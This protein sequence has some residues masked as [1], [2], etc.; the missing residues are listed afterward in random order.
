MNARNQEN[1]H[2]I[3]AQIKADIQALPTRYT[4][5]IRALR[6]QYSQA[7]KAADSAFMFALAHALIAEI[8]GYGQKWFA[9]E[10]LK[11]H[12]AAFQ[13]MGDAEME[14]FSVGIEGWD[15]VDS[16]TRTLSGPAWLKRQIS[17]DLIH[18]WARSDNLWRRRMALVSTV[19]LNMRSQGGNG[20]VPRTLAICEMLVADKEDMIVKALSWALRELVPHDPEAVTAFIRQH[21]DQLA[22]RVK[23]EVRNKLTSGLKNPK[24]HE[25]K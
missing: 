25:Q 13:A 24:R 8:R 19:A 6:R 23:R 5:P 4:D 16:F 15:D 22:G 12:K 17:D 18:R 3:A 14:A 10:L 11:N 9:Y 1:P 20:D 21:E 2:Q 7:L